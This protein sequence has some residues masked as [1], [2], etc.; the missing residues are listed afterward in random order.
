MIVLFH[1]PAM[2]YTIT[3]SPAFDA[4]H[5]I[6]ARKIAGIRKK[7]SSATSMDKVLHYFSG[8]LINFIS[9]SVNMLRFFIFMLFNFGTVVVLRVFDITKADV[10]SLY[11][12]VSPGAR[13]VGAV[14]VQP[15]GPDGYR[16]GGG[17]EDKKLKRF[18]QYVNHAPGKTIAFKTRKE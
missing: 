12:L 14:I 15:P 9:L 2:S 4:I 17:R 7:S 1:Y 8:S 13:R 5:R 3:L 10:P 11:L 18:C 6:W 16:K